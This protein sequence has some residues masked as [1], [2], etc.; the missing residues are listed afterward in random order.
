MR[1]EPSLVRIRAVVKAAAINLSIVANVVSRTVVVPYIALRFIV[2]NFFKY[3]TLSDS[4]KIGD[5][6]PYFAGDYVEPGYVSVPFFISFGK[7]VTDPVYITETRVLRVSKGASDSVSV[8]DVFSL[9]MSGKLYILD[10]VSV[11]DDGSLQMQDYC[12]IDYFAGDYLG[13]SRA[14]S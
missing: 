2:G 6:E 11:S 3:H 4:V 9:A 13:D 1:I 5:V 14:F 12:G 8:S 7:N 10:P